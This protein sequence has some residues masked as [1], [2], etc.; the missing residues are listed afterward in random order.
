MIRY[1]GSYIY[2]DALFTQYLS[3]SL[4]TIFIRVRVGYGDRKRELFHTQNETWTDQKLHFPFFPSRKTHS[5][6]PFTLAT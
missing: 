2:K 3:R 4:C 5:L 1:K 6:S